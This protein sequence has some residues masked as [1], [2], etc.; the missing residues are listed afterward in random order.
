METGNNVGA[1][2][3]HTG[4]GHIEARGVTGEI[5]LNASYDDRRIQVEGRLDSPNLKTNDGSIDARL[6]EG[7]RMLTRWSLRSGDGNITLRLPEDFQADLEAHRAC[8][9]R[10]DASNAVN[11]YHKKCVHTRV[12]G[13]YAIVF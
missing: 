13:P 10:Q 6:L 5:E 9:P 4:D 12:F 1:V 11:K 8:R 3:I 7:S 2:D